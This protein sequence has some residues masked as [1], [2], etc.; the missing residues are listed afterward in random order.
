MAH[1]AGTGDYLATLT[2][3]TVGFCKDLYA[4]I[5]ATPTPLQQHVFGLLGISPAADL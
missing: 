1:A 2:R 3:N 5:L 4:T